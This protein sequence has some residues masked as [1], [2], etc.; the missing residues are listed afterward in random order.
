M[1]QGNLQLFHT[2]CFCCLSLK[3]CLKYQSQFS[4]SNPRSPRAG[5]AKASYNANASPCSKARSIFD[6]AACASNSK[7]EF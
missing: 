5:V 4:R 3:N 6:M 7:A 2:S 1:N